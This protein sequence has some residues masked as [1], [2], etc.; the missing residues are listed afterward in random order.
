MS[1]V[2]FQVLFGPFQPQPQPQ[3]M[4]G[5]AAARLIPDDP[6]PGGYAWR[7]IAANNREL[8]R[9]A[10]GFVSYQLAR[11][12]IGQLKQ[13][14]DRLVQHSTVDPS[15]RRWGWLFDLDGAV[16][17]VSGRW[18]ERELHGRLGAAK[19]V[20]LAPGAELTDGVVRLPSRHGEPFVE[21][22]R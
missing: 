10:L 7:L 20:T 4:G 16:V 6:T 8:G 15:T 5:R 14:I 19:F 13:G 18:Y 9:S 17:A 21:G 12:G 1:Q 22:A 11:R 3:L 2:R